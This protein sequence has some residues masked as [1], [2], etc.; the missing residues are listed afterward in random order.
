MFE[1]IIGFLFF[2]IPIALLVF[3]G[4]S[5]YRYASAKKANKKMPETFS[6]REI[7]NRKT[8]LIIASVLTGAL[9]VMTVGLVVLVYLAVAFM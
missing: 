9:V 6:Q 1:Y 8:A 2:A 4:V 5:I 3:L 7:S